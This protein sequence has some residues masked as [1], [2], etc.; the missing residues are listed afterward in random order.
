[1]CSLANRERGCQFS[2]KIPAEFCPTAAKG[3]GLQPRRVFPGVG[4]IELV[5]SS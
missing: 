5:P 4:D 3:S 1:M 2:K